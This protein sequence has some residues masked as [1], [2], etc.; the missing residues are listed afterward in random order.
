MFEA[1]ETLPPAEG[2]AP[3]PRAAWP[4]RIME[5]AA[6]GRP[7]EVSDSARQKLFV[8]WEHAT[9][10]IAKAEQMKQ[11]A[12]K[13]QAKCAENIVKKLGGGA[14]RFKG[15]LYQVLVST[16]GVVFLREQVA[17]RKHG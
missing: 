10:M 3:D 11:D 12:I 14:F 5:L 15:K 16:K 6:G 4:D 9:T 17:K 2:T 1:E 8:E 13:H 7:A